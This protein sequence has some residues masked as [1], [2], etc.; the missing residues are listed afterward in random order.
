[1]S[2][3]S[4]RFKQFEVF[5]DRCA[6]KVGM[7]G[8]LLGAWAKPFLE[9]NEAAGLRILDVGSG[10]G[11]IALMLAQRFPSSSVFGIEKDIKA[12]LQAQEN[13]ARSPWSERIEIIQG[14]FPES[15]N[16]NFLPEEQQFDLIV[17]NPPY[18]RNALKGSIYAR[19]LARH[20]DKLSF[21]Q[22]TMSAAGLLGEQGTFALIVPAEAAELM[23]ELCWGQRLYLTT[24]C[25]IEHRRGKEPK[26]CLMSFTKS[27]ADICRQVLQIEDSKGEYTPEFKALTSE[28][29]L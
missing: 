26:R 28:F 18:Y 20:G 15:I 8:V 13:V 29:Y 14:S 24:I 3:S 25:Q 4:F 27:R 17:S 5:H 23:E 1:M 22:L 12:A 2:S 11:L 7:D 19:N 16:D 10:S 9:L 6:M 21:E